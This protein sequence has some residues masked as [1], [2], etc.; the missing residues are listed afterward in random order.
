MTVIGGVILAGVIPKERMWVII[1]SFECSLVLVR[2]RPC[3]LQIMA[4]LLPVTRRNVLM[5]LSGAVG[6]ALLFGCGNSSSSSVTTTLPL[7]DFGLGARFPDGSNMASMFA[8]GAPQRA[9]YVL[10]G[11]D[12]WPISD[13]VPESI[14]LTVNK[15]G[16]FIETVMVSRHG[17][18]GQTPYYP[19]IFTPPE[20]GYYEIA[21]SSGTSH[22]LE[23]VDGN[24]LS[25][26]QVGDQ[27][28]SVETPTVS[29]SRGVNPICTRFED[30][31]PLHDLTVT[32]ALSRSGPTAVLV[33]TPGFCQSDVCGPALDVLIAESEKLNTDWSVIHADVYVAPN[34]GDFRT[35]PIIS[36]FG[37]PFEPSLVVA[38]SDGVITEIVHLAMDRDEISAALETVN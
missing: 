20:V 37:L 23:V 32:E 12:G 33:S 6:A 13:D 16:G 21:L 27:L 36:A 18:V 8:A 11:E 2:Q 22:T 10:L 31:C 35:A 3:I 1:H 9:P 25:I 30:P 15:D 29:D 26:I 5:S 14:E 34:E 4:D 17:E 38:N 7:P 24:Q 19:L 28:P